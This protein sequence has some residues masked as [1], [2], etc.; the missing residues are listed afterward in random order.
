MF[1]GHLKLQKDP[2]LLTIQQRRALNGFGHISH[3]SHPSKQIPLVT[4]FE[5]E[6]SRL[7]TRE[8]VM[9]HQCEMTMN[10]KENFK[11]DNTLFI[12]IPQ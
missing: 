3:L 1:Q 7:P 5:F 12:H 10:Q 8:L 11:M 6:I 4:S 2:H 9:E